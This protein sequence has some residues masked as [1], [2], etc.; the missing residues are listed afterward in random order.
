MQDLGRTAV[1]AIAEPQRQ[2]RSF[3]SGS[4]RRHR[5]MPCLNRTISSPFEKKFIGCQSS[6][7]PLS[8]RILIQSEIRNPQSEIERFPAASVLE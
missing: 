3:D 7:K 8:L 5:I 4:P 2:F 1:S 6:R